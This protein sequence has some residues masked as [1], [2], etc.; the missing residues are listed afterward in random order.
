MKDIKETQHGFQSKLS[1]LTDLID[2]FQKKIELLTRSIPTWKKFDKGPHERLIE[3]VED[4][5]FVE[6]LLD[7]SATGSRAA[8][9]GNAL[10][11]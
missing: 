9:N 8:N 7:G 10:V 3:Y 1:G 2:F 11:K 5:E 4:L 6:T